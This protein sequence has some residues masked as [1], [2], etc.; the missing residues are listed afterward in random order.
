L[1]NKAR[2]VFTSGIIH[3]NGVSYLFI[4]NKL[5]P[6]LRIGGFEMGKT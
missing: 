2:S 6:V 4:G 1:E 5:Q 3:Q